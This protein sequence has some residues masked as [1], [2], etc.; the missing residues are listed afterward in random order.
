MIKR[1][2]LS[3]LLL[4]SVAMAKDLMQIPFEK[5]D[6]E[7]TNLAE[8]RGKVLLLVNV[9]SRCGFT[10]QY[11]ELEKLYRE[12]KE[13]GLMVIGFPCND[14]GGQEPG[15][16]DEILSFCKT[17]YGVTFP[18]MNKIHVVGSEQHPLYAKLLSGETAA[19]GE[20]KWNFEKILIGRDGV[21][22]AK[23]GSAAR[24]MGKEVM[25]AIQQ[26]LQK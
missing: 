3:V 17:E 13:D 18:I 23:F 26:E 19:A 4:G 10:K 12:K 11:E 24:P 21:P 9:A 20:I 7:A 8:F 25:A 14:F 22:V 15:G 1:L 6:G 16:M 2:L 5:A